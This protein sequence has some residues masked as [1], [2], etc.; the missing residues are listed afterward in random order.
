ME[1]DIDIRVL[2]QLRKL[3]GQGLISKMADL[4][5]SHA[6]PAMREAAEAYSAGDLDSVRRAAHSLKS[7]AGNLGARR[8]QELAD[9]I[10]QLAEQRSADIQALLTDLQDAYLKAKV[11][12]A[13]EINEE[14]I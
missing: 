11:R 14:R 4:F 8:V 2:E 5:M 3:G 12:L 13:Q 9:Q 7:S 6:E 10:E 1:S